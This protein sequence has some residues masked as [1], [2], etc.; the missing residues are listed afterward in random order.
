MTDETNVLDPASPNA[1]PLVAVKP[2]IVPTS[3]MLLFRQV[4]LFIAGGTAFLGF[5]RHHDIGGFVQWA[6]TDSGA[7][8]LSLAA[9]IGLGAWGQRKA[10]MQRFTMIKIG[11]D[12]R[13]AGV[14]VL[15][16]S[17]TVPPPVAST[18]RL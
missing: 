13:N 3:V 4:G 12:P 18:P 17:A 9:T 16:E 10:I 15:N 8:W 5:A 14:F 6:Q 1:A 2:S 11:R 7:Q